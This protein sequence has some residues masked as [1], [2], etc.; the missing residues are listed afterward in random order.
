[1][2][3]KMENKQEININQLFEDALKTKIC[4]DPVD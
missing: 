2:L 3:G 1:M 4:E